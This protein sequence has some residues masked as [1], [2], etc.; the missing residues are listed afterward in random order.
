MK[1]EAKIYVFASTAKTF[2]EVEVVKSLRVFAVNKQGCIFK[3]SHSGN[4]FQKFAY[5]SGR[6]METQSKVFKGNKLT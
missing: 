2:P 5:S 1:M 3:R 6:S 4:R